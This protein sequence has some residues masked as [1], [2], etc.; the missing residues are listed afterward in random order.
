MLLAKEIPHYTYDDYVHWEGR[1]ELIEGH[2]IAMSPLPV[3]KHQGLTIEI[4]SLFLVALKK[5]GCKNCKV[6]DPIDYKINDDTIIQ[7]D[8]LIV[9]DKIKKKY[10][11][12]AP[13]LVVEVLSPSTAIRD[14]NI[15]YKI[16][17]KQGVKYYLIVDADAKKIE[18]HLLINGIYAT[19]SMPENEFEF[20]LEENCSV[21][22]DFNEIEW[23]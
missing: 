23:D 5:N 16:Y 21:K 22:I 15:K 11:D 17:Q 8:I 13:S 14:K 6:Y 2:P 20:F 4:A 1:W 19:Q 12:F 10:L 3:P 7:P 9:C 18:T